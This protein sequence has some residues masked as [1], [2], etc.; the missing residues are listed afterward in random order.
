MRSKEPI[1]YASGYTVDLYCDQDLSTWLHWPSQ[2]FCG[3]SLRECL[4]QARR[5]GWKIHKDR[6]ATC[7]M[8]MKRPKEQRK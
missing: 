2:T 1:H 4:Q 3:E 7:G 5:S 8:C 6:T